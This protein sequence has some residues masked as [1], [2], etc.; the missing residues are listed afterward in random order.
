MLS[1]SHERYPPESAPVLT[2]GGANRWAVAEPGW[3]GVNETETSARCL[4]LLCLAGEGGNG[5]GWI[6]RSTGQLGR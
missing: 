4:L 1:N 6:A 5:R 2:C 3:T